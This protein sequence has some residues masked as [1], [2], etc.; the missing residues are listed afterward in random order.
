[1]PS[2]LTLLSFAILSIGF[3]V[4]CPP[5][6]TAGDDAGN[7]VTGPDA[8]IDINRAYDRGWVPVI[9]YGPVE[10]KPSNYRDS[11]YYV[12]GLKKR[13]Q[14][15]Q[16]WF[17]R[18]GRPQ[19]ATTPKGSYSSRLRAW[20][21]EMRNRGAYHDDFKSALDSAGS[22]LRNMAPGARTAPGILNRNRDIY[23]RGTKGNYGSGT[24]GRG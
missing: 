15:V 20:E 12:E 19:G 3:P 11:P 13:Q 16:D 1:M 9:P 2:K 5:P 10:R 17:K 7:A 24:P 21:R 18:Y 23:E 14:A 22:K 4:L 8:D 6:A